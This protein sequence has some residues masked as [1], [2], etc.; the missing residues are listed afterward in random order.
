MHGNLF[1]RFTV[2]GLALCLSML[3]TGCKREGCTD[4][5]STNYDPKAKVD[6]GTCV[7]PTPTLSLHFN[8]RVG[9]LPFSTDSVY[10]DSSG[11]RFSLDKA[12]FYLSG[13]ALLT[14]NGVVPIAKYLQVV[15]GQ[16]VNYSLGEVAEEHING[17]R[18]DI[19]VDS[20]TN[21]SDPSLFP[22][23]H[24]LSLLSPTQDHWTWNVGYVF[25]KIEGLADTSAAMNGVPDQPFGMHI[26]TDPLLSEVSLESH[27]HIEH[28]QNHVLT[29]NIDWSRAFS[30]YDFRRSTHTT[31]NFLIAERAMH[32]FV[33]GFTVE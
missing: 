8:H 22:D 32:N 30:G 28:G 21:H 20:V 11:R 18:F 15:A 19:G 31:D 23:D 24:A 12:R 5:L 10:Q 2:L 4:P 3:A 13:P 7:Y 33:T 26:A 9:T 27:F 25:L 6:D 29:I 14:D 17:F 16:N 1:T